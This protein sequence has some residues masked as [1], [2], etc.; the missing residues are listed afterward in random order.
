MDR[1]KL[2]KGFAALT[3]GQRLVALNEARAAAA[4]P[5]PAG[6]HEL[7][8][9]VEINGA[10]ARPGMAVLPGDTVSTGEGSRAIYLIGRDVFLQRDR[11]VIQIAG[12]TT[13]DGLRVVTGKILSV[14]GK[15]HKKIQ[16]PTATIGIRGTACYIEAEES[17]VY[18]CLCYGRAEIVPTGRPEASETIET[19]YHDRP[20]FI[21]AHGEQMMSP[22]TVRNH[23]DSEL[24]LLEA[25]AGRRPAFFG[26]NVSGY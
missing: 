7:S 24:M 21:N 4:R 16:T 9:K 15:G 25:L 20:M 1:R 19:H 8:G 6:I 2:L 23:S 3:I 26:K 10:P 18:F 14:F 17:S 12:D 11:S 13:R 5:V 22:S